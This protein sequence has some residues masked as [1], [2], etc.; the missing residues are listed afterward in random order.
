[1]K[2]VLTVFLLSLLGFGN[3]KPTTLDSKLPVVITINEFSR[4]SEVQFKLAEKL[5]ESK[6]SVIAEQKVKELLQ[7]GAMNQ[8][9]RDSRLID[10]KTNPL[11]YA[12]KAILTMP[13]VA[14]RL[15]VNVVMDENQ[16]FDSCYYAIRFIPPHEVSA[17]KYY[18]ADSI[19]KKNDIDLLIATIIE[20]AIKKKNPR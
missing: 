7:S 1:M 18:I 19:V 17:E 15:I 4:K 5:Q 14:Q 3:D 12:K 6:L 20:G 9:Q 2:Y 16:H 11:E 8:A 13:Y 10:N